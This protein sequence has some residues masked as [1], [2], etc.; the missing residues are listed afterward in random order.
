MNREF[1]IQENKDDAG[2]VTYKA[3]VPGSELVGHGDS[4]WLAIAALCDALETTAEAFR[5]GEEEAFR[6]YLAEWG[7]RIG[8]SQTSG[9]VSFRYHGREVTRT[10]H[11]LSFSEFIRKWREE[12][13][14]FKK[15]SAALDSGNAEEYDRLS[16]KAFPLEVELFL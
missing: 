13:E 14:L 16:E 11:R 7:L 10:I 9:S 8:G 4:E 1:E 12:A 6:N 3:T 5:E 2:V 15:A